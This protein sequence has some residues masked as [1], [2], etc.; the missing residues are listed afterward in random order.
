MSVKILAK[1]SLLKGFNLDENVFVSTDDLKISDRCDSCN[2]RA[3]VRAI[4]PGKELVFCGSHSKRNIIA[5]VEAGW[6]I[7]DQTWKAFNGAASQ[8][9]EGTS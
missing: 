3:L 2:A 5:L 7:D 4:K 6:S 1:E 8:P 9:N